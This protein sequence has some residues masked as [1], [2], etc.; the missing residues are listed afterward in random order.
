ME[1]FAR[2]SEGSGRSRL[3]VV[4]IALC[5]AVGVF[6]LA[7]QVTGSRLPAWMIPGAAVTDSATAVSLVLIGLAL[8]LTG[9]PDG[10]LVPRRIGR[11]LAAAVAVAGTVELVVHAAGGP[12]GLGVP[13][14]PE[15]STGAAGWDA[16]T[17]AAVAAMACGVALLDAG[18]VPA[19]AGALVA[20]VGLITAGYGL[21]DGDAMA[22]PTGVG[23]VAA[24]V[25]VLTV[26]PDRAFARVLTGPGR[27]TRVPTAAVIAAVVLLAGPAAAR[28]GV[29]DPATAAVAALVTALFTGLV[30]EGGATRRDS[31]T[32][33]SEGEQRFHRLVLGAPDAMVIVDERGLIT[34]VNQQTERLFRYRADELV[35]R[36]VEVL[37]P[38]Q[39]RRNHIRHRHEYLTSPSYRGM[40]VGLALIGQRSDGSQFPVEISLAPLETEQ[41]VLVSAAIRDT[42]ERRRTERALALARDEA[43]AAVRLKSQF[44]AMV[45]HEIRTPMNGVIGLTDLLAET[46]LNPSQQRYVQSIRA[47][48]EALLT[49]INDILDFS[50]IE[51]GKVELVDTD[52][53]LDQ[54]LT[55]VVHA[56]AEAARDKDVDVI[57]YYPPSLPVAVRGDAGRLRQALL[58]LLGNAVKFTERG[59]VVL[60]AQPLP[61]DDE[62]GRVRVGFAVDDTGIGIAPADLPSLYE[63]FSQVEAASN[64]RFGGTGL[65]LTITRQLVELMGGELEVTSEPGRGSRFCFTLAFDSRPDADEPAP[66]ALSGR[67]LLLVCEHPAGRDLIVEH[68]RAWGMVPEVEAD[69]GAAL[70]LLHAACRDEPFD[71][72]AIDQQ[73]AG[74]G[75]AD[76]TA[77]IANDE[78]LSD[79]VTV[80]LTSGSYLDEQRAIKAGA[81]AVLPKPI[82]P[83][84]LQE[85]LVTALDPT[86]RNAVGATP[87]P[88]QRDRTE[89]GKGTILLAEDNE[90]NQMVAVGI[91]TKLGYQVDIAG[92][93]LEVLALVDAKPYVAILM[94]CQMPQMDGFTATAELRR[95]PTHDELPPIIAM[96]AGALAADKQACLA[97]GMD[98]YVAK[99]VDPVTLR[100]TLEKWTQRHRG[101]LGRRGVGPS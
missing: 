52:F 95:R 3:S 15:W 1:H 92:N 49:I 17:A 54:V 38:E 59:S 44:V 78:N 16:A 43:L 5:L 51:A 77:A 91:L 24:W 37:I 6:A 33:A 53:A 87:V 58:N 41:G 27:H 12:P 75:T 21:A 66:R 83:A 56:A 19:T 82:N 32:N 46:P 26:R 96:T 57:A 72:V 30:L 62:D 88:V 55:E 65:G 8:I 84:Q 93:G 74:R 90:I 34:L 76:L 64:R 61:G 42:S 100:N 67:R 23:L 89:A 35:G 47:S 71:V 11:T 31:R 40:G 80:V 36:P 25:A 98:D 10:S 4:A 69:V 9:S 81:T 22:Y 97:A 73:L 85:C 86:A 2:T 48:G 68:S 39:F 7:G 14:F 45:S 70:D 18:T 60:R 28:S 101:H 63:P 94:D 79:M 20:V 13:L 50:K 29:V 99:P